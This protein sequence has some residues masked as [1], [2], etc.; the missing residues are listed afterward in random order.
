MKRDENLLLNW[1]V[2]DGKA[3][4]LYGTI[5]SAPEGLRVPCGLKVSIRV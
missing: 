4:E 5:W 3:V 2:R 1:R